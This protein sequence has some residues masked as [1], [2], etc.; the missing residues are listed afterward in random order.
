MHAAANR[1]QTDSYGRPA[2]Q[3]QQPVL[4]PVRNDALLDDLIDKPPQQAQQNIDTSFLDDL[5]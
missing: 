3:G 4:Q 5:L 2:Y 1:I